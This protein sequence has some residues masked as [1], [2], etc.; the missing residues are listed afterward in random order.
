MSLILGILDFIVVFV[1]V[2]SVWRAIWKA[3]WLA[4]SVLV[5]VAVAIFGLVSLLAAS[6]LTDLSAFH[7]GALLIFLVATAAVS[8]VSFGNKPI[9]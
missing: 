1:V 6:G 8:V 3:R 4:L 2:I 5:T 9:R 7:Q